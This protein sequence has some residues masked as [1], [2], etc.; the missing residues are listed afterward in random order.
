MR[1]EEIAKC[2]AEFEKCNNISIYITIFSDGSFCIKEFW[3]NE[4]L[5]IFDEIEDLI[6]YLKNKNLKK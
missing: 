4:V 2:I 5:D 6:D 1:F 3:N